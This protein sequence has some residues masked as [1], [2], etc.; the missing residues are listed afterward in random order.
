MS[1]E[2]MF[3]G[4]DSPEIVEVEAGQEPEKVTITKEEYQKMLE[5]VGKVEALEKGFGGMRESFERP[6]K[7]EYNPPPPQQGVEESWEDFQKRINKDLFGDNPAAVLTEFFNKLSGPVVAQTMEATADQA[8]KFLALDEET[9]PMFKRYKGDIEEFVNKLPAVQKRNPRVWEYAYNEVLKGKQTEIV[10]ERVNR[11]VEEKLKAMG[12]VKE[13]EAAKKKEPFFT[14]SA[15]AGMGA[16]RKKIYMTKG[17]KE[18]YVAEADRLG[19]PLEHYL[20]RVG[21]A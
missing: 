18:R 2:L 4:D 1:D 16:E 5:G 7:V 15:T 11:M 8:K 14:E 3:E 21:K 6:V 13:G 10:E 20:R 12:V 17:E 19:I 9:G